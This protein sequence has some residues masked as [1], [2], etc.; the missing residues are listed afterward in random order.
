MIMITCWILWMP[1][2]AAPPGPG[3]VAAGLCC[4]V[5]LSARTAPR[6]SV[7]PAAAGRR[8]LIPHSGDLVV[9]GGMVPGGNRAGEPVAAVTHPPTSPQPGTAHSRAGSRPESGEP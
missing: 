4:A 5:A 9:H 6:A 7:A 2:G 1:C 8:S 3:E